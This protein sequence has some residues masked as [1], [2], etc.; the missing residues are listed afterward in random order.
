MLGEPALAGSPTPGRRRAMDY[1]SGMWGRVERAIEGLSRVTGWIGAAALLAAAFIVTEGVII[2]KVLGW[3]T[4][5]QIEMA[6]FLL[7]YA[8]FVGSAYTQS[9]EGHLNVDLLIVYLPPRTRELVL[10]GAAALGAALCALIAWY[11]WPMWWEAWVRNDHSESLWGPPLW[12]PYLFLPAGMTLLF[13]QHLVTLG[14]R[15]RA[16]RRGEYT[17]EVARAELKEIEIPGGDGHG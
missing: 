12:I 1:A 7:M 17:R 11:A 16:F 13:L 10:I 6:V 5:W 15:I 14:R 4:V 9:R 8:C 3:S 2:R